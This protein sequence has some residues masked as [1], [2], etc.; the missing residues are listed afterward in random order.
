MS[1]AGTGAGVG[2]D[3]ESSARVELQGA[4]GRK[5]T[6]RREKTSRQQ[7]LQHQQQQHPAYRL[8]LLSLVLMF[9]NIHS[10]NDDCLSD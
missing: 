3:L 10:C 4:A 7:Q 2:Q 6:L 9:S 8:L 1:R 5:R